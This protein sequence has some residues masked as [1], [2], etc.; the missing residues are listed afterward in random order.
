MLDKGKED[1][2]LQSA[3]QIC[4]RKEE[5]SNAKVHLE[6]YERELR[7]TSKE[8]KPP[9]FLQ[10][11]NLYFILLHKIAYLHKQKKNCLTYLCSCSARLSDKALFKHL[12]LDNKELDDI[13]NEI[14]NQ[15]INSVIIYLE[16]LEVYPDV[17]IPAKERV[18]TFYEFLKD[19]CTS[20]FLKKILLVIEENDKNEETEEDKQLNK[21]FTPIVN[22][23]FENLGG[24]NLVY[25]KNDVAV[26]LKFLSSFKQIAE[27]IIYSKSIFLHLNLRDKIRDCVF[28]GNEAATVESAISATHGGFDVEKPC[29][30]DKE[31]NSCGYNLQLNS[32]LGRLLS[33]T[34]IT[35]PN[36]TKK[37]EIAM[38]K[39]FYNST[40]NTLNKMTLGALK[41]TYV[42]LRRDTDWIL[43]NCVEIIK[44]LLKGSGE[45]KKRVLLWLACIII[46]NEKKTKIM[47]H[48]STYPQSL[49]ASYGLF[50][51][52]LGE[53]SYG[54]C[55]NMFW[56]LLCLCE[57]ITMNKISDF[58]LFF[59][60]R[61]DPFSKF[62]LK[63][64]TN[65]SSFE[66]KSNVENIKQK[67]KNSEGFSK[68][69]KFITCIFWITFKSLSVFFKPAI[70]EFMR[71]VQEVPNA[72]D[73]NFYYMN[74][75][76]WKI[77]LYS[78]RFIQLLFK[79]LHLTM[80]YFLHVAYL[81]DMEGNPCMDMMN[82]LREHNGNFTHLVLKSCPPPNEK[83]YFRRGKT[84][85]SLSLCEN[86]PG[87]QGEEAEEDAEKRDE[88]GRRAELPQEDGLDDRTQGQRGSD[89]IERNPQDREDHLFASPQFSIIPTFFL[90]DIFDIIYLLY[91]LDAFK[92]PGNEN[93]LSY[94]NT[95]LFLA[96]CIF[97]MLSENHIKS[98]HLRCEAAPKTFTYLYR[99]DTMKKIIE[100]SDLT[101]KYIIKSLTYVF[102]ASQK[103]EYTERMQ[104]RVRIVENFNNL[105]LNEI[106]VDQFTQL[107]IK[108]NN[109]FVHLIHLLL[110]D[111]NFL[112]EEVV[113]YLSEIKRRE[114]KKRDDQERGDTSTGGVTSG[115]ASSATNGQANGGTTN[116]YANAARNSRVSNTSA[117]SALNPYG[118]S[119]F[120]ES[121]ANVNESYNSDNSDNDE[122]GG[123]NVGTD[124]TNESMRNLTAR[125]KMI[126]T[127]C[128]KSCIFLNLLCKN[129]PN[130]IVT[131]NTIL[132]QIVTCLNCYFDYLV[133]PKCLN[134]KVKNMEQYN[135][136]PQLW[137]TSIVESYLFLLNS[138]KKNEELLT[139]EI[140]NEGR[141]YKPEVFN[142]AYYICKREGLLRKEDLNKFKNF[143][144]QI[145]DMKDEVELFD[146]VDDIPEK[147][148]DPIL[149]DIMLDPVLLP[150]SGIVIDR[151]NIERH[152]MSEPNDPF[153]R[154]PLSKEQLVPMPELKEEIHKF[155]NELKQKKR[156]KKMNLLELD[157]QNESMEKEGFLGN[158]DDAQE[159]KGPSDDKVETL[160]EGDIKEKEQE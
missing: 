28:S 36:I 143:C 136:R 78:S 140:A 138:D 77:F 141:Y 144:Q 91:E 53:N 58:D 129:Y 23:I 97:T 102:I 70:D 90:N 110:N 123:G 24:R 157:A 107:V 20:R 25:P 62:L 21:F 87:G 158:Q 66:E 48:Y 160:H 152:L 94:L 73:K 3:L 139:R 145:I 79:F 2:V 96:F 10:I 61:D 133:G 29:S 132:S 119:D 51:K 67:V 98:I 9:F 68:E 65:Q 19:S 127:Y 27:H 52:L 44:N 63:N 39:Y 85:G 35:M 116:T 13:T 17:T 114:D 76:T 125:T 71:I 88:E 92:N 60:L 126:I 106:Y 26:L 101:R 15:I 156:K 100:E 82:S 128:Y 137:L 59:F 43:E 50:L 12:Q 72:K 69:P 154:A 41:N 103:G 131:S 148:L 122:G 55:L 150:T 104:T 57:P 147:Y 159:Q 121:A 83:N 34:V 84:F 115:L 95:D 99:S 38:Y 33:P 32:L 151:K 111:V 105:F 80:A 45:S 113:S 47:Y 4:L 135:F 109:L 18:H 118:R 74:I 16:N 134:I 153:N 155:I 120:E 7:E 130:N 142:K 6:S 93:F 124:I 112:V 37:E 22:L 49:D 89:N 146:D 64:I 8:G 149:Q 75:H 14:N 11:E 42:M 5:A 117:S 40:T 54:F 30:K 81:Y 108:N 31:I 86:D 1:A 56:V 46:S